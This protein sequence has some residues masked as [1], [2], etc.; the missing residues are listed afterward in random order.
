[1]QSESIC[2]VIS[3][4]KHVFLQ[5]ISRSN[6][7]LLGNANALYYLHALNTVF[8]ILCQHERYFL[9]LFLPCNKKG[10]LSRF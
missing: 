4:Q 5:H 10:G 9:T 3:N 2:P 7:S 1:M 8:I 6:I